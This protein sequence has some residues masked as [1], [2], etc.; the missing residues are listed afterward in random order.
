MLHTLLLFVAS[1][2]P[3]T[4]GSV[5][6]VSVPSPSAYALAFPRRPGLSGSGMGRIASM[7]PDDL[8]RQ[9]MYADEIVAGNVPTWQF[10]WVPV[11]WTG[12][13]A[14]GVP[15]AVQIEVSPD[16]LSVGDDTD[17]LVAPMGL[18]ETARVA[19]QLGFSIPTPYVVDRIYEAAEHHYAP[20]PLRPSYEMRTAA[21]ALRHRSMIAQQGEVEAGTFVAG[22]KKDVVLTARLLVQPS[23]LAI[24]G[25]HRDVDDPIQPVCLLHERTYADYSH[26]IRAVNATMYVDGEPMPYLDVLADP[27]LAPLV[28]DEGAFDARKVLARAGAGS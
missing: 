24:Y 17:H 1:P 27:V 5:P 25:W 21:Y 23:R 28:S 8:T 3:A 13:D 9:R 2:L 19:A 11:T 10:R 4:A 15:H 18:T 14:D 26:G 22:H 12:E 16:Y 7:V 6:A 20:Q